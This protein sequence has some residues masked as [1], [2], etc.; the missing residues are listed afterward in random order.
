MQRQLC[1]GLKV[2]FRSRFKVE[3]PAQPR[4]LP[5]IKTKT[6]LLGCLDAGLFQTLPVH[7]PK[8]RRMRSVC[9]W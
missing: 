7:Y 4:F 6:I 5:L 9:S 2:K 1:P 8:S 3:M